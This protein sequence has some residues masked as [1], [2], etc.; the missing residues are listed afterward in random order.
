MQNY[1]NTE[2]LSIG[3]QQM[4]FHMFYEVWNHAHIDFL[5]TRM[6][7]FHILDQKTIIT[8]SFAL[9]SCAIPIQP[10]FKNRYPGWFFKN[11]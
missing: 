5:E 4:Y 2:L 11:S 1:L 7:K 9:V 8:R 10:Y 3:F 6:G